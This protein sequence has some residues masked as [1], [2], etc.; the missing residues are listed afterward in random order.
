MYKD[1]YFNLSEASNTNKKELKIYL[2]SHLHL[3]VLGLA[4]LDIGDDELFVD[5]PAHEQTL[6]HINAAY[7]P[8]TLHSPPCCLL[9]PKQARSLGEKNACES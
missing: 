3:S 7:P 1:V 4:R 8:P 9:Q 5:K 6:R 2:L